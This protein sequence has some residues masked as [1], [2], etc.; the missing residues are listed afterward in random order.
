MSITKV[1]L[2]LGNRSASNKVS[3]WGIIKIDMTGNTTFTTPN[4]TLATVD[5][6]VVKLANAINVA[7]SGDH[8]KVAAMHAQEKKVD[9]LLHQL[10]IYVE[11]V[12]N[13]AALSGA[14]PVA[15]VRNA[16]MDVAAG[17][18]K[19]P[20]PNAV[21]GVIGSSLIEGQIELN[22]KSELHARAYIIEISSDLAAVNPSTNTTTTTNSTTARV[23]I[24]WQITD[25][26]HKPHLTLTGL[27][28][29]TKYAVRITSSGT[30]GKSAPSSILV[31]KVL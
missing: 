11:G 31:V 27:T 4:P 23:Y 3:F 10:G 30:A 9:N 26:C 7:L 14:D 19:A 22:F 28:S 21:T 13:N 12:A 29:G 2:N 17:H 25:V 16:G 18:V 24:N 5:T 8:S 20:I 1:R 6:E 15:I